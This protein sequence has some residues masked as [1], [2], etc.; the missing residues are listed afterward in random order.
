MQYCY[1]NSSTIIPTH[2]GNDT[3]IIRNCACTYSY[4]Q[5]DRHKCMHAQT[6][7]H[8]HTHTHTTH[9]QTNWYTHTDRNTHT[10]YTKHT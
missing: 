4:K 10:K 9:T 6:Y 2:I 7:T 1:N 8:T 3:G 5:A